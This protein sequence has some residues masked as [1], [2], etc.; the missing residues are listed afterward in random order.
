MITGRSCLVSSGLVDEAF[1]SSIL[2][3]N[4]II[5]FPD[6]EPFNGPDHSLFSFAAQVER[7]VV[8]HIILS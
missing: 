1:F 5:M 3:I 4:E 7:T 8:H 6:V 2:A